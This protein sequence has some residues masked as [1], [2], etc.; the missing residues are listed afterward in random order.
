MENNMDIENR[1]DIT[2]T[3][4]D[5][6][7]SI[8]T[9]EIN[10]E[11]QPNKEYSTQEQMQLLERIINFTDNDNNQ[12]IRK[13]IDEILRGD[14]REE[15]I[16]ELIN[17][18]K[19]EKIIEL[20]K[21]DLKKINLTQIAIENT[22]CNSHFVYAYETNIYKNL[23][24]QGMILEEGEQKGYSIYNDFNYNVQFE[25][26]EMGMY[27]NYYPYINYIIEK[28]N[29]NNNNISSKNLLAKIIIHNFIEIKE[30]QSIAKERLNIYKE[31]EK[32]NN[33]INSLMKENLSD[34]EKKE[35]QD[36]DKLLSDNYN[37]T[38]FN[39]A[40]TYPK[41][42]TEFQIFA[43]CPEI[44]MKVKNN[45]ISQIK[46]NIEKTENINFHE[47]ILKA[48]KDIQ[49]IE[50]NFTFANPNHELMYIN[51]E[52]VNENNHTLNNMIKT[53][54]QERI[55]RCLY[56]LEK[57][58]YQIEATNKKPL[59][60][61]IMKE[62]LNNLE[63]NKPL[64]KEIGLKVFKQIR[65]SKDNIEYFIRYK[66]NEHMIQNEINNEI[67][68]YNKTTNIKEKEKCIKELNNI[69]ERI[70][71]KGVFFNNELNIFKDNKKVKEA[72]NIIKEYEKN[73]K[74][75]TLQNKNTRM[76]GR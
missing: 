44:Y 9:D 38:Y 22:I 54:S 45:T 53:Y 41:T 39:F 14:N 33:K 59:D 13:K 28:N 50:N 29:K 3:L 61:P 1:I 42:A 49:I 36:I 62:L 73:M 57:T 51:K 17:N 8:N 19:P 30:R 71:E 5:S 47:M 48:K 35:I 43:E 32:L 34:S 2:I 6:S 52:K 10:Q 15:K 70:N 76:N 18:N 26:F 55:A 27:N 60:N 20:I 67:S 31:H 25:E 40:L 75:M 72:T 16:I 23:K 66:K 64:T 58:S 12:K 21:D 46:E 7:Y 69:I 56:M 4:N 63:Q 74:Y 11:L 37:K 65:N 24:Y 68:K